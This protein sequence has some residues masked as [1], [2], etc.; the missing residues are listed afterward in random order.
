MA[1]TLE[2]YSSLGTQFLL[3]HGSKSPAYL[4]LAVDRLAATLPRNNRVTL[5]G[6]GHDGPENDGRP[7]QV[8]KQL[9]RFFT[10]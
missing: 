2:A 1:D 10:E 9:R 6:L 8:A 4:K 3:L 5:P 7:E